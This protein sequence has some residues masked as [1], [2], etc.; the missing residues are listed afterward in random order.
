MRGRRI[1][2]STPLCPKHLAGQPPCPATRGPARAP[3]LALQLSAPLTPGH[4]LG[5]FAT[6]QTRKQNGVDQLL[7]PSGVDLLMV[8]SAPLSW[9]LRP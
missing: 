3:Q 9:R 2:I 1:N 4:Q 5:I 6:G 7:A 8:A